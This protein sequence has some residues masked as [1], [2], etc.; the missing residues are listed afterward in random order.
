M[1]VSYNAIAGHGPESFM[2]DATSFMDADGNKRSS[3]QLEGSDATVDSVCGDVVDSQCYLYNCTEGNGLVVCVDTGR[4][5]NDACARSCGTGAFCPSD[6]FPASTQIPVQ[7]AYCRSIG[8]PPELLDHCIVMRMNNA[9]T[10]CQ[11]GGGD[12]SGG[13]GGEP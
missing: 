13:N 4:E 11:G 7:E 8:I 5:G 9:T 1:L 10:Q 3:I 6:L 12:G 2:P